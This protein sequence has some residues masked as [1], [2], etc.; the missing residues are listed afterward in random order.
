MEH[1]LEP[2]LL[3]SVFLGATALIHEIT[4]RIKFPFVVALLLLGFLGQALLY[5]FGLDVHA[6]LSPDMIFYVLLP[7]LLFG[8]ALH[9]NFHH[10]KLQFKTI[11]FLATFGLLLSIFTVGLLGY[12]FLNLPFLVALLFGAMISATDPI[13]VLAL[14]KSV[15]APKRLSLVIDGESMFN[16][17]TA[18]I[19]FRVILSFIVGTYA[20]STATIVQT[21]GNFLYVFLGSLVVGGILGVIGSLVIERIQNNVFVETTITVVLALIS[22]IIPEHFF[23]LSGVI[24]CVI[25]GITVGN[26]GETKISGGV[27]A[28]LNEFWEYVSVL[29]IGL[30]FFFA[31][32]TI[33]VSIF[34]NWMTELV[35]VIAIVLIARAISVYISMFVTNNTPLFK[36]EPNISFQ[37][38]HVLN[39]GGLRGVIPLVLVFALPE[40]FEYKEHLLLFTLGVL[41]FS[42]FVNGLTIAW[43]L[44]KLGLHIPRKE[45][46]IIEE[47]LDIFHLEQARQKLEKFPDVSAEKKVIK[48]IKKRLDEAESYHRQMLVSLASYEELKMSLFVQAIRIERTTYKELF[49]EGI[50]NE[51]V[52][53]DLESQL[54]LQEDA[55]EY[56]EIFKVRNVTKKGLVDSNLSYRRKLRNFKQWA[57]EY[58]FLQKII[59]ASKDQLIQERYMTLK[60]RLIANE[61]VLSYL[62]KVEDLFEK[63]DD[64]TKAALADVEDRYHDFRKK[65]IKEL[66]HI[67]VTFEDIVAAYHLKLIEMFI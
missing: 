36:D 56:P 55:L 6:T 34:S 52:F 1:L 10:F 28:F 61:S 24:S 25:A 21:L 17:A 7:L 41:L 58:S 47:E 51:A 40:G 18:V 65:N 13:A 35:I 29:A 59:G 2:V 42:L 22:F 3:V 45:E 11:A 27:A 39:W 50:I 44:K 49:L 33:D 5:V 43:L 15:G 63:L 66:R 54:D 19:V 46:Q 20:I 57:S 8:A 30:V 14:F 38:Q 9:I 64:K 53:F 23:H 12:Q 67:A 4:E 37:W 60:A 31:S 48:A 26:L 16:D 32:F 62:G